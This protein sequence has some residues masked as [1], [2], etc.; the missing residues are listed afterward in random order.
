MPHPTYLRFL[1]G[2]IILAFMLCIMPVRDA[3]ALSV[4]FLARWSGDMEASNATDPRLVGDAKAGISG[5]IA[6]AFQFDGTGDVFNTLL[7]LPSQGTIALWVKPADLSGEIYGIFGTVGGDNGNDRLWLTA[8]GAQGGIGIGP[9]N[10]VVNIGYCCLNEIVV[11]SPLL[12]NT[13]THLAL[14]FDYG[15]NSYAL[16]INGSLAATLINPPGPTRLRPSQPLDFG[17]V[18]SN[19]SQNFFWNGL[20]DEVYVFDQVLSLSDI[21]DLAMPVVPFTGFFPPIS[22]LPVLNVVQAGQ[23][24][25]V[26][27]SLGEHRGWAIFAPGYPKSKAVP[28]DPDDPINDV[29]STETA[30]GSGL[31]YDIATDTYTYVWKTDKA[32]RKSCRTLLL[33]LTDGIDHTADFRFK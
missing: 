8:R 27:F 23:A 17:G 1:I 10:L 15:S 20:I 31:T 12:P 18:Q 21:Q 16:Y 6:G 28:C 4:G 3:L 24:I 32:W 5:L 30:G 2:F 25:P 11:P 26:K 29:Q 7:T 22:N 33:Q 19:F 13:W 14:T 9:N